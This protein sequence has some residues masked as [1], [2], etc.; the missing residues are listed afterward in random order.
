MKNV[1]KIEAFLGRIRAEDAGAVTVDFV[2]ITAAIAALSIAV[3]GSVAS[4][5]TDLGDDIS[6]S[7]R[8]VGMW[9]EEEAGQPPPE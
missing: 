8:T 3:L 5:A 2:V 9:G 7:L 1:S 4:G 6:I